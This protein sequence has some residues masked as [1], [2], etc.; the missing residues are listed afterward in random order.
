VYISCVGY[1]NLMLLLYITDWKQSTFI[2][3][4]INIFAQTKTE[5]YPAELALSKFSLREGLQQNLNLHFELSEKFPTGEF[6]AAMMLATDTHQIGIQSVPNEQTR[7]GKFNEISFAKAQ[8]MLKEFL[9]HEKIIIFSFTE[10]LNKYKDINCLEVVL[11]K[12]LNVNVSVSSTE[13]LLQSLQNRN[14]QPPRD[15]LN[16][17]EKLIKNAWEINIAL[18]LG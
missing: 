3:G 1:L 15:N 2:L 9:G 16:V 12:M 18:L 7:Q 8:Q 17:R 6:L 13:V 11:E 14:R 4:S 5:I 10:T